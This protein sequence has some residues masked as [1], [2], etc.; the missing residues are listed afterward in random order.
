MAGT[1]QKTAR[2]IQLIEMNIKKIANVITD[3]E[4]EKTVEDHEAKDDFHALYDEVR[5]A[6]LGGEDVGDVGDALSRTFS[7]SSEFKLIWD[8]IL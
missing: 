6:V 1:Y 4:T 3:L 7:N 2:E 5:S 8:N